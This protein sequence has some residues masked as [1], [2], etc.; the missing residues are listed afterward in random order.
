M[1]ANRATIDSRINNVLFEAKNKGA[2]I[3]ERTEKRLLALNAAPSLPGGAGELIEAVGSEI[4]QRIL[5]EPAPKVFH[6]I[7]LRSV[8]REKTGAKSRRPGEKRL[9]FPGSV[10]QKPIPYNNDRSFDLAPQLAEKLSNALRVEVR[11]RQETEKKPYAFSFGRDDQRRYRRNLPVRACP[12]SQNGR[13]PARSPASAHQ[14]SHQ[15]TAFVYEND[16]GSESGRFFLTRGH[17]S[18]TQ[19]LISF[20]SRSLARLMGFCGVQ[21]RECRSLLTW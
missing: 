16:G 18:L 9:N 1:E 12:L 21:P 2:V 14:R 5:F 15:Q 4:G 6:R 8:C 17:S 13:L 20:S 3:Y 19:R 7:K 11:V 10:G